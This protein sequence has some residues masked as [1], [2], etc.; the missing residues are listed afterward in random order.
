MA[1]GARYR[2]ARFALAALAAGGVIGGTAYFAGAAQPQAADSGNSD[3]A[4]VT[5][6]AGVAPARQPVANPAPAKR[7]RGS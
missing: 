3:T 4:A 2:K 1:A 7:S 6:V 5:N